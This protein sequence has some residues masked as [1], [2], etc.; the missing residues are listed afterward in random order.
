MSGC[1]QCGHITGSEESLCECCY[2]RRFHQVPKEQQVL[3][4][5]A[6]G[7]E[8]SDKARGLALTSGA[9]FYLAIILILGISAPYLEHYRK[10][11]MAS[12]STNPRYDFVLTDDELSAVH[13]DRVATSGAVRTSHSVEQ[14]PAPSPVL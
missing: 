11:A 6:E 10:L 14:S 3:D 1:Y 9:F 4:V 7:I 13:D 12:S 8:L 2:Q 5:P